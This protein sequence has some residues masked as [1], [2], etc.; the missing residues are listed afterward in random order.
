MD[1]QANAARQVSP[2]YWSIGSVYVL[3][4][5]V[6]AALGF[7]TDSTSPIL[8]SAML[9]LPASLIALPGYYMAYGLLAL[10]PGASPSASS[11]SSRSA[12]TI[13]DPAAWFLLVTDVVGVLAFTSAALLNL[14]ALRI[15]TTRRRN[16]QKV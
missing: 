12:S 6:L 4:V 10:V 14:L 2:L 8:I 7:I 11:S 5:A 3:V 16:S 13:G 15:L 1:R 9:S